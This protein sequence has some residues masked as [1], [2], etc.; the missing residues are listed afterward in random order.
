MKKI[1]SLIVLTLLVVPL[2]LVAQKKDTKTVYFK[3]SMDCVGCEKTLTEQLKFEKGIKVLDIDH[4]SN[5][6][7]IVYKDGKNSDDNL[8]KS[9][10]KKGYKAEKITEDEFNKLRLRAGKN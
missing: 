8:A 6:I 5:T 9:V 4:V 2:T 1:L 10:G 7:K 3:S